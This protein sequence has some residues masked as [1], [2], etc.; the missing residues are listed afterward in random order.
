MYI[1][2]LYIHIYYTYIYI[3]YIYHIYIIHI[4]IYY[5]YIYYIY[6]TYIYYIYYTYIYILYYTYIYSFLSEIFWNC[7]SK[8]PWT[9]HLTH[10]WPDGSSSEASGCSK[11]EA[12]TGSARRGPSKPSSSTSEPS[13]WHPLDVHW[14]SIGCWMML[15]K[16]V[17]ILMG[18][19]WDCWYAPIFLKHQEFLDTVD[20][21]SIWR[22]ETRCLILTNSDGDLTKQNG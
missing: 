9:P 1:Y 18:F 13:P 3:I 20:K 17:G 12:S 15:V 21:Q 11:L 16:D 19:W 4:Y 10:P 2:I 7:T 14:M 6:Y 8:Q 22:F 5:T